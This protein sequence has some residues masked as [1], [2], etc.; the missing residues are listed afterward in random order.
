MSLAKAAG[1]SGSLQ[2]AGKK[3]L[4]KDT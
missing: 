3:T 4:E 2:G 1:F